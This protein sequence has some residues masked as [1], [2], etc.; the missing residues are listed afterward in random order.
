MYVGILYEITSSASGTALRM[1]LLTRM[2]IPRTASGWEAMY[3]STDLK[4]VLSIVPP[5]PGRI[6]PRHWLP[7]ASMLKRFRD[8]LNWH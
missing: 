5:D 8:L 6:D 2:S 3:S 1:V 4:P 7:V